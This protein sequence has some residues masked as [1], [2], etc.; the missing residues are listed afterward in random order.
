[1]V[2]SPTLNPALTKKLN[3]EAFNGS[4]RQCRKMSLPRKV[5]QILHHLGNE[6]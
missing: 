6:S 2:L 1:M 4:K 5:G 3:V